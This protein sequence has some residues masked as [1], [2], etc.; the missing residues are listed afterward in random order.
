MH[1]ERGKRCQTG[2]PA[3]RT[4]AVVAKFGPFE[5]LLWFK[6]VSA[7]CWFGAPSGCPALP[8]DKHHLCSHAGHLR[9]QRV[10]KTV[11]LLKHYT[12]INVPQCSSGVA[13]TTI[14]E[15]T[16]A[17]GH[18]CSLGRTSIVCQGSFLFL[19]VIQKWHRL[20]R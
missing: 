6:V 20:P 17:D 5:P 10:S 18:H 19:N 1:K 9:T 4:P 11:R 12:G 15:Q 16:M 8:V 3:G 14:T 7:L 13:I 2:A